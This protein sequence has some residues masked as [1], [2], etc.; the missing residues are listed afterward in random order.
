MCNGHSQY[1]I[2]IIIMLANYGVA[3][4]V[5]REVGRYIVLAEMPLATHPLQWADMIYQYNYLKPISVSTL[6]TAPSRSQRDFE[7]YR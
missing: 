3:V 1:N 6:E 7:Q 4:G 5:Y 2:N